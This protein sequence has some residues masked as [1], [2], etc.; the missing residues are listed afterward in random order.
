MASELPAR[1]DFAKTLK[2]FDSS[3]KKKTT[4]QSRNAV[5]EQLRLLKQRFEKRSDFKEITIQEKRKLRTLHR[6]F[7]KAVTQG[8]IT[9]MTSDE[10]KQDAVAK[11]DV[12]FAQIGDIVMNQV[13]DKKYKV[14]NPAAISELLSRVASLNG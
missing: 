8:I 2:Q 9:G 6:Q 14:D 13:L 4:P 5:K 11:E 1:F 10:E 3:I 7:I 12:L